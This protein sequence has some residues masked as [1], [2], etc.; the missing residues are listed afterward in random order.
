MDFEEKVIR[1]AIDSYQKKKIYYS[2]AFLE[3]SSV[4]SVPDDTE[5]VILNQ[6][7]GNNHTEQQYELL[8]EK[9]H[10]KDYVLLTSNYR[11]YKQ[12]HPNIIYFPY[13]YLYTLKYT[14]VQQHDFKNH[15]PYKL[16]CLNLNPWFHRVVNFLNMRQRAWFKECQLSFH[17]TYQEGHFDNTNIGINTLAE[18]TESEKTELSSIN[19]PILIDKDWYRQYVSNSSSVHQECYIDYVTENSTRQEFITEKSWK[20]LFSGQLFLILGTANTLQHL[21]DL[22]IDTFDDIIDH[23]SYDNEPDVRTK[24]NLILAQVD[25]LM[26]MNLEQVW[27]DTYQRRKHNYELVYSTEF[28]FKMAE[29]LIKRVS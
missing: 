4:I 7:F 19:L 11:Y 28:Q 6:S 21:R 29:D 1:D 17:W 27:N 2:A 22:G 14:G 15:R 25:R 26:S 18:I 23:G 9:V 8:K 10:G 16:Q 3:D 12:K 24:I 5:L 13:Y 20:P